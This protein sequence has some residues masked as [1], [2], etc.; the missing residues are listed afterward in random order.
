MIPR[1][2]VIL[3]LAGEA[4]SRLLTRLRS[5]CAGPEAALVSDFAGTRGKH[6]VTTHRGLELAVLADTLAV[7]QAS[8]DGEAEATYVVRRRA[9]I[10]AAVENVWRRVP[11]AFEALT[12]LLLGR[13]WV[14]LEQDN[15]DT[16]DRREA[17]EEADE[18]REQAEDPRKGGERDRARR[19]P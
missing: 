15:A 7:T 17:E 16:M 3:F 11:G 8:F 5:A 1:E 18:R 12:D 10:E 4:P 13:E 19:D 14:R 9:E 6:V 2:T